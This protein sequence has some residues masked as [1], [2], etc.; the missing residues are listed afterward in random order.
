MRSRRTWSWLEYESIGGDLEE[1]GL[2]PRSMNDNTRRKKRKV[3]LCGE[4]ENR[5][6]ECGRREQ[7]L[8]SILCLSLLTLCSIRS[9]YR[10]TCI[11]NS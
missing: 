5:D 6:S 4:R 3:A 8:Y 10:R 7:N 11:G 1:D 2:H 9:Y